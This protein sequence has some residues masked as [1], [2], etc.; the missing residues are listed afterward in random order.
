KLQTYMVH[1]LLP[2]V[3]IPILFMAVLGIWLSY[4]SAQS[5]NQ[6]FL[7]S[8]ESELLMI[9]E[10]PVF[11]RHT[12]AMEEMRMS[13]AHMYMRYLRQW[14]QQFIERSNQQET[15][16]LWIQA[17][18]AE[19]REIL[20]VVADD[21]KSPGNEKRS[22]LPPIPKGS[23]VVAR[24]KSM[25]EGVTRCSALGSNHI[26]SVPI[27][28]DRDENGHL[29]SNEYLGALSAG[30]RYPRSYIMFIVTRILI[31][32]GVIMAL[33]LLLSFH[34][35]K[36]RFR[37][38]VEPVHYL[39]RISRQFAA[40][41]LSA[42]ADIQLNVAEVQ[43]M[44]DAF[45]SMACDIE[46]I[47]EE[48]NRYSQEL[49]KLNEDLERKVLERTKELRRLNK[50]L[51]TATRHKSEFLANMSHELRTPMNAI[52][53]FTEL[54]Q[55]GIYGQ[56]PPKTTE[57]IEKIQRNGTHLLNLINDVLDLSKIEAGRIDLTMTDFRAATCIENVVSNASSLAARKGVR[58]N[59]TIPDEL[60]N[61]YGDEK[62][63]NQI[64]WNLVSNAIKFTQ[65]GEVTIGV[66][67]EDGGLHF[68]VQDTGIGIPSDRLGDLFQEFTQL[69]SG[70]TKEFGGTGLGL[71]ISLKLV[72]MHG[73]KIWAESEEGKGSVFHFTL[74]FRNEIE[75]GSSSAT[76]Q[77][78]KTGGK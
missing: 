11:F 17:V 52:L 67:A 12:K 72:E 19:G 2:M 61:G 23:E 54:I 25:K 43:D 49:A 36:R 18:D 3:L 46:N 30:F 48:R 20:R 32:T 28:F 27:W 41:N 39:A 42:R 71:S 4:R 7:Q 73:G 65:E 59:A 68:F 37:G 45:N 56:I 47:L 55:D 15:V 60:P 70:D 6:W 26:I 34:S 44:V 22:V 5:V 78:S 64:L 66:K 21:L 14:L 13:S 29:S 31:F 53:G 51:R 50:E 40:G 35:V 16:Y 77:G 57:I 62:R 8:R 9:A 76:E 75:T 33:A 69:D 24:T 1:L 63:V 10:R 38:L 58:V 74:P